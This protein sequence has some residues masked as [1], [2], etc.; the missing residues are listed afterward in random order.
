MHYAPVEIITRGA[1]AFH[2]QQY[3]KW[4]DRDQMLIINSSNLKYD[5]V[6]VLRVTQEFIGVPIAVDAKNFVVDEETGRFC[7]LGMWWSLQCL[8]VGSKNRTC[9]NG[10]Y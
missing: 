3:L 8:L 5:P 9:S 6:E 1:Y 7:I 2:I 10:T 4:F